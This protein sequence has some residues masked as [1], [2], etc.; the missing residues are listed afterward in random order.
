MI[1]L[2]YPGKILFLAQL[3]LNLHYYF[4]YLFMYGMGTFP[5][6]LRGRGLQGHKF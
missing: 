1:W 2:I 3:N 4:L 5:C 6:C